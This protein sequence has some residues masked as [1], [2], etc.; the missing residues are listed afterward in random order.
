MRKEKFFGYWIVFYC[1]VLMFFVFTIIKSLHSLFLVPVTES[2]GMERSAFSL[3]FTI[4]GVSVAVA[5]PV[6]SK[7][8]NHHSVKQVATVGVL[9]SSL[10]FA[11]YSLA[12]ESWQFYLIAAV[13]GAGT[14]GCTNVV[15][16][17][18]IN[19]WFIDRKG[20][21]MGIAFTGSGF[22][23]ALISP[24]LSNLI[25]QYGWQ[26]SYA[27]C[28]IVMALVCVPCTWLFAY[29]KPAEKGQKPYQQSDDLALEACLKTDVGPALQE[30]KGKGFFWLYLI[31]ILLC[32]T[33]VGGVHIH[34]PAYFTDLGY[35]TAFV[36]F[37]YSAYAIFLIVG[38]LLLGYIFD[39]KGS[40]W[41][42]VFLGVT[43]CTAFGC[44]IF[45]KQYLL[46]LAFTLFYGC[47]ATFTSVG[48]SY[49]TNS[50]FGQRDYAAIISF[51]NI[52]Y[53]I[54][55]ATGPFISGVV[56]DYTGS[57][58]LI[59][60]VYLCIFAV[61]ITALWLLKTYLD[62]HYTAQWCS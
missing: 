24:L 41:G 22:G 34:I 50:F 27:A 55:A 7:L 57:Y 59:W 12:R 26:F 6:V 1:F 44:L 20:M 8:L 3:I 5:L 38:K 32:S 58:A 56:Y 29:K 9:M 43:V 51:V 39:T 53:V 37:I 31:A 23:T 46:A 61:S 2:L 21:A 11:A 4:T 40:K 52:F 25:Q 49:L 13:V 17:L 33:V 47:G 16:A 35:D 14:A 42:I 45:A 18:L 48:V 30:I 60:K 15:I 28:G 10:G 62:K 19:N 54:G 36:A